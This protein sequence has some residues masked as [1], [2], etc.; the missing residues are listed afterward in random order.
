VRSATAA[1]PVVG[2]HEGGV[3]EDSIRPAVVDGDHD[4]RINRVPEDG[5]RLVDPPLAGE[6]G[7][8]VEDVLTVEHVEDREARRGIRVVGRR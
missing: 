4:R 2:I 3:L 8:G 6:A 5:D 7:G 1:L